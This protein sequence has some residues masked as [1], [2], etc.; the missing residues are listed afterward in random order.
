M[1]TN[2]G[3][4][5]LRA[6]YHHCNSSNRCFK[7]WRADALRFVFM[8][9]RGAR[10]QLRMMRPV[11]RMGA[12]AI[13]MLNALIFRQ[14]EQRRDGEITRASAYHEPDDMDEEED[15]LDAEGMNDLIAE[16]LAAPALEERGC[17]FLSAVQLDH[18]LFRLPLTR[19]LDTQT[20]A[21]MYG[22][23][24]WHSLEQLFH[25]GEQRQ[26][27]KEQ[28][29]TRRTRSTAV[30]EADRESPER[31]V[32]FGVHEADVTRR[33]AIMLTGPDI[34]P[35]AG[36]PANDP[37][38]ANG[39]NGQLNK[40][41]HQ[42]LRDVLRKCPTG[43]DGAY[44]VL[45]TAE[46]EEATE[47]IYKSATLP[48]RGA[49]VKVAQKQ[50]WDTSMF[51]RFFPSRKLLAQF[52]K[53]AQHF[54]QCGYYLQW[55]SLIGTTRGDGDEEL[56]EGIRQE[57]NKLGWLPWNKAD[58]M[59]IVQSAETGQFS[60]LGVERGGKGV[61]IAV[62]PTWGRKHSDLKLKV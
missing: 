1:H 26:I 23:E 48:F 46:I 19:E 11:L 9:F 47:E 62:N 58:R 14:G 12:V 55:K 28:A 16:D 4:P 25:E 60:K 21:Q 50:A 44:C 30:F 42:F 15:D 51:D 5:V 61:K 45:E 2:G 18:G 41:W 57:Y 49:F 32:D 35:N 31:E 3:K 43:S 24:S 38:L 17:Y 54:P 29:G 13:W 34:A 8:A 6:G 22:A 33:P 52:N 40:I 37:A 20:Y 7:I 56:R 53:P 27:R 36:R 10:P 39:I 59:W